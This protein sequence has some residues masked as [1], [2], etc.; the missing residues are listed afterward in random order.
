MAG[1]TPE[2]NSTWTGRPRREPRHLIRS[3]VVSKRR[4]GRTR[5]IT[6]D[7]SEDVVDKFY[8]AVQMHFD[9]AR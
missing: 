7:A 1:R 6:I 5:E 3:R 2:P 8:A 4:Y 9:L